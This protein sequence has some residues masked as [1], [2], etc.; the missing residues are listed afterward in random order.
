MKF[1]NK[2]RGL[3]ADTVET[4]RKDYHIIIISD[5]R[6]NVKPKERRDEYG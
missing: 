3:P 2:Q 4:S 6:M 1:R 5:I